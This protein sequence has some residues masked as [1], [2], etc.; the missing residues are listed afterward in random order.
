MTNEQVLNL[1][2]DNVIR[3]M[4]CGKWLNHTISEVRNVETR[5]GHSLA[6]VSCVVG[7]VTCKYSLE[8]DEFI[9]AEGSTTHDENG[10]RIAGAELIK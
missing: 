7:D 8:S 9:H 10:K 3:H 6:S 4:V 1:K 2:A 5:E